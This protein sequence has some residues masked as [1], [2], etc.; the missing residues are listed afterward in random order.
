MPQI[1][2]L[3]ISAEP[4]SIRKDVPIDNKLPRRVARNMLGYGIADV[5]DA[6]ITPG[7]TTNILDGILT[8]VH[9]RDTRSFEIRWDLAK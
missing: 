5:L 6:A 8:V 4:S 2:T 3:R 9:N 7:G 1:K